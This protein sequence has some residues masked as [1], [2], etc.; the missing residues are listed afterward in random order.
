M[1]FEMVKSR[2]VI[3][4]EKEKPDV[5]DDDVVIVGEREK[6]NMT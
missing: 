6:N 4:I 5:T 3:L 1:N 2:M